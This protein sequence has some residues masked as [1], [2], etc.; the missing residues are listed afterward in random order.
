MVVSKYFSFQD[1][2]TRYLGFHK[3]CCQW[4]DAVVVALP[5]KRKYNDF[6]G[7]NQVS[8]GITAH[9]YHEFL[10]HDVFSGLDFLNVTIIGLFVL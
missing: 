5:R 1:I 6:I 8:L 3:R 10:Y 9:M 2:L 7:G 4:F